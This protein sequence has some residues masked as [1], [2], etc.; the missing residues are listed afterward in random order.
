VDPLGALILPRF[1]RLPRVA[2]VA[3]GTGHALDELDRLPPCDIDGRQK[4]K[5]IR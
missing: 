2:E 1:G 4:L 3:T 5:A